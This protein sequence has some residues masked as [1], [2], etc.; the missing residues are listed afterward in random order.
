MTSHEALDVPVGDVLDDHEPSDGV[1]ELVLLGGQ[2]MDSAPILPIV[3]IDVVELQNVKIV[4]T[5]LFLLLLVWVLA[6]LLVLGLHC[7]VRIEIVQI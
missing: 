3:T 4:T 6:L 2:V 1:S 7:Q 5:L